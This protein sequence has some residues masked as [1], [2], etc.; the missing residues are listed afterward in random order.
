M[1]KAAGAA[2]DPYVRSVNVGRPRRVEWRGR[3]IR[4][5]IWKLPAAGPVEVGYRQL[6]G[7]DQADRRVHGGEAKAVYAYADEDY[8]W[9][10]ARWEAGRAAIE[11]GLFGENLTTRGVDLGAAASGDRWR[12]GSAE[13]EVTQPRSP[14]FKLGLRVG[15][16][17]FVREFAAA[18]R[19]GTYLRV[20][21][22]GVIT[23][24][25]RIAVVPRAA[26]VG[27]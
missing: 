19:F 17:A 22:P 12:V 4:T 21:Q 13:L 15:D 7:D 23:A 16:D 25:D 2:S 5:A 8:E 3:A 20:V 9:W 18:G 10:V 14:C 27:R 11:V 24:G 26:R 1:A 6:A